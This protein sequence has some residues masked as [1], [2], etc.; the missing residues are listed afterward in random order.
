MVH[1][2]FGIRIVSGMACL[3]SILLNRVTLLHEPFMRTIGHCE[4]YPL[5][6][7]INLK[8]R[9]CFPKLLYIHHLSF[10]PGT[11]RFLQKSISNYSTVESY[12][13]MSFK[14]SQ[15]SCS[16]NQY[17]CSPILSAPRVSDKIDKKHAFSEGRGRPSLLV[18][19]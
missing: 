6:G 4:T 17:I 13:N 1:R 9:H 12:P 16:Y 8:Y 2:T 14:T 18:L 19:M 11:L 5:E 7:Q 10:L 15:S 3:R